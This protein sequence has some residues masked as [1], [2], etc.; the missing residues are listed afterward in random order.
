MS[1]TRRII[2]VHTTFA[3][4][5]GCDPAIDL[6]APDIGPLLAAYQRSRT[7]EARAALPLKPGAS[8]AEFVITRLSQAGLRSVKSAHS[9]TERHQRAVLLGCHAFVDARGVE[10]RAKVRNDN[11]VPW[12][13]DAWLDTIADEYG[14]AAVDEI[15]AAIEQWTMAPRGALDPFGSVPGLALVR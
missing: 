4:R 3:N 8:P 10:R 12:A 5:N 11:G 6:D 9:A 7:D 14:G 1:D 2:L 13:D 15:G